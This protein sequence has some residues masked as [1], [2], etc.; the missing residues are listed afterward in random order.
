MGTGP[1]MVA[2][3]NS[4][5][6]EGEHHGS[7][8]RG[9]AVFLSSSKKKNRRVF[10]V[11]GKRQKNFVFKNRGVR[12]PRIAESEATERTENVPLRMASV[13]GR[14]ETSGG[15]SSV[16]CVCSSRSACSLDEI[17]PAH[18]SLFSDFFFFA[19]FWGRLSL[20]IT[21]WHTTAVGSLTTAYQAVSIKAF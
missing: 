2:G 9:V 17:A 8:N 21:D 10:K 20:Q 3:P 1:A 14:R 7:S 13:I 18:E 19:P 5:N 11:S 16:F 4:D 15:T 12:D 6:P